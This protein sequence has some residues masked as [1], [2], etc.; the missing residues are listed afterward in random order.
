M[1][2][3][4]KPPND[5]EPRIRA[6]L[7]QF[8]EDVQAAL[9]DLDKAKQTKGEPVVLPLVPKAELVADPFTARAGGIG[10]RSRLIQVPDET[11]GEVPA[12]SDGTNWR[13]VTDRAVV[14]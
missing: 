7:N 2:R 12:F 14:S 3:L 6:Y 10:G 13:R 11:G 1:R 9:D 5:L 4:T 8:V